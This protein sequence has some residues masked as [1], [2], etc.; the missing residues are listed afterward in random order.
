MKKTLAFLVLIAMAGTFPAAASREEETFHPQG[1][2]VRKLERGGAN[3]LLGFMEFAYHM[4]QE[5]KGEMIPPWI[6]GL[7]KSLGYTL[8]R[9]FVGIYEILTFPFPVPED[10]LPVIE[11]EFVWQYPPGKK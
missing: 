9:T 8:R 5:D 11:P 4:R 10:Y 7:G 2:P 6:L 1:S 3:L